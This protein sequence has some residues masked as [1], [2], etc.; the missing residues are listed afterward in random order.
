MA[1]SVNVFCAMLTSN[2]GTL[3]SWPIQFMDKEGK[4]KL[5]GSNPTRKPKNAHYL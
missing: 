1:K 3:H 5:Y 4:Y 2:P